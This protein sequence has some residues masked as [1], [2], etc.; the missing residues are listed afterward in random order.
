VDPEVA[1]VVGILPIRLLAVNI[2]RIRLKFLLMRLQGRFG[3][4]IIRRIRGF[5][6]KVLV[7]NPRSLDNRNLDN[8]ILRILSSAEVELFWS[9]SQA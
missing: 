8:L 2:L 4:A 1:L 9:S 3:L 7:V 6:R 5:L